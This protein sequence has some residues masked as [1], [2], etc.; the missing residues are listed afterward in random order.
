VAASHLG[1]SVWLTVAVGRSLYR[2]NREL[3]PAQDT[4]QR[5]ARRSR[6]LPIFIGLA[7][8]SLASAAYGALQYATLSYKVWVSERDLDGPTR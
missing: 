2:S 1:V 3:R 6:N 7:V 4:R 5:S 8:L